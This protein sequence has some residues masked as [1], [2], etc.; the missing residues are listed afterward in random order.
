MNPW[1]FSNRA[2]ALGA[3]KYT[4]HTATPG[5]H[6]EWFFSF[7]SFMCI[8]YYISFFFFFFDSFSSVFPAITGTARRA[9]LAAKW[10][11]II[12]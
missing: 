4:Y 3:M 11:L 7:S 1:A 2:R 8:I 6:K 5:Q 12:W 9:A 10:G